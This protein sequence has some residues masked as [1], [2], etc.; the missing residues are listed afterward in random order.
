MAAEAR[1]AFLDRP[2]ARGLAALVFLGCLAALAWL[3]RARLLAPEVAADDPVAL[4]MAERAAQIDELVS[5]GRIESGQAQQLKSRTG[6]MC[7]GAGA[8]A[9]APAP[10][11]S[12]R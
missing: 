9:G 1:P 6:E 3:E 11:Q 4:C 5:Q 8:A 10:G 7:A 12:P 2:L